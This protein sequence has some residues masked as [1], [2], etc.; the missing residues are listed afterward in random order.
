MI[1][2]VFF[3]IKLSRSHN[4][5]RKYIKTTHIDSTLIAGI[6]NLSH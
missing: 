5:D 2:I 6:T 4:L 3:P 1:F